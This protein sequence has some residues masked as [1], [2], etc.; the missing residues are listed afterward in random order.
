LSRLVLKSSLPPSP[1]VVIVLS[2]RTKRRQAGAERPLL[3]GVAP[4]DLLL[5]V[6]P[7]SIFLPTSA[8]E[9]E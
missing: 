6:A 8:G 3:R 1:Q 5:I 2:G 4:T 7:Q 9:H